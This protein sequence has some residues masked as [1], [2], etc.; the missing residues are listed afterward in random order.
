MTCESRPDS[1]P[2]SFEASWIVQGEDVPRH[3]CCDFCKEHWYRNDRTVLF[4]PLSD[5]AEELP[6]QCND[7]LGYVIAAFFALAGFLFLLAQIADLVWPKR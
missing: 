1:L 7:G 4:T 5:D 3:R 6:A 2:C